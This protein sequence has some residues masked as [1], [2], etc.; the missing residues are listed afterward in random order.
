MRASLTRV[1][2]VARVIEGESGGK[3]G[4]ARGESRNEKRLNKLQRAACRWLVVRHGRP[5]NF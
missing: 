5:T 1:I 2:F 4:S 3:E